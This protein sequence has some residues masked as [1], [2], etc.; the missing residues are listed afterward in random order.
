VSNSSEE[1]TLTFDCGDS[2]NPD[3]CDRYNVQAKIKGRHELECCEYATYW[4]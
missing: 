3:L 4:I 1:R 2:E